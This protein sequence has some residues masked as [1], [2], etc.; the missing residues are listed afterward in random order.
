M[1]LRTPILHINL[2]EIITGSDGDV[3]LKVKGK[4]ERYDKISLK[5]IIL[6]MQ[7][8]RLQGAQPTKD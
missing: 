4:G 7:N 1:Y 6:K 2:G 8:N 5:S 3:V